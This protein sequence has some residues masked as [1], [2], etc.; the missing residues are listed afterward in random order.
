MPSGCRF[1]ARCPFRIEQCDE[2]P[3]LLELAPGP[4]GAL[5]GDAGRRA[6]AA[7]GDARRPAAPAARR[8]EPSRPKPRAASRCCRVRGLVKHFPL[9]RDG[10]FGSAEVVHAV[11][12]VDLDVA[13]GET[14][15]LVGESGCGKSTLA[16]VLVAHPRADRGLDRLRRARTS[17]EASRRGDPAAAPAHADGVPGPLC[18]AQPAHDGRRHPRASRCASTALTRPRRETARAGRGAARRPSASTRRW[19]SAIRTNSPAAS[20]S[21]SRSPARSRSSPDFIIADEP[22][23]SL[24]VNIQA[25]IINL[26]I[27]LQ[28]RFGLTYLFI[29]HDLAVVRHISRPHRGALSRQGGGDR[30]G[31]G[32]C[33]RAPLH[34]YTRYL[35]SAVP[36]PDAAAERRRAAP[37]AAGR[38]AERRRSAVRLPLPHPLPDRASRFAPRCRRRSPST[39][40]GHFAACHFAGEF[41]PDGGGAHAARHG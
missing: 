26:L 19:R 34:P 12:G 30:A 36:I 1:A 7:A 15:G 13:R 24:D 14:V 28:E 37:A 29:A 18:V 33:S 32:R 39:R 8:I 41:Q 23:S 27:D 5:L 4:Q 11:D 25:Q 2:H 6:A 16:R 21:A 38:A 10:F 17:R 40:R 3:A 35:I 22:I 9:P 31:R 20:A